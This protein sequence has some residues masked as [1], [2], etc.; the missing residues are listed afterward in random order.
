MGFETQPVASTSPPCANIAIENINCR[1]P[2]IL[3]N[4][5]AIGMAYNFLSIRFR[6]SMNPSDCSSVET[7]NFFCNVIGEIVTSIINQIDQM[8]YNLC[9]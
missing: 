5:K 6:R 3:T 8:Q 9:S 7:A 2:Q 4:M 1:V